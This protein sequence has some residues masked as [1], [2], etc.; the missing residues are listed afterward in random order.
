VSVAGIIMFHSI[1]E[2]LKSGKE[3]MKDKVPASLSMRVMVMWRRAASL[4][5]EINLV[6]QHFPKDT[7]RRTSVDLRRYVLDLSVSLAQTV[8]Q[9]NT[10]P[11]LLEKIKTIESKI[12]AIQDE[13]FK[14]SDKGLVD[15]ITAAQINGE[16]ER[17]KDDAKSIRSELTFGV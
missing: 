7:N 8:K 11:Q 17:L 16:I 4:V 12:A 2:I 1:L 6:A 3:K 15:K 9:E 5:Q 13:M 14:L 10:K